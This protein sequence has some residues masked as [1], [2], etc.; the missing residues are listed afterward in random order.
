[1]WGRSV[2]TGRVNRHSVC[3]N[4]GKEEWDWSKKCAVPLP[5]LAYSTHELRKR[6]GTSKSSIQ[7]QGGWEQSLMFMGTRV[8]KGTLF[9]SLWRLLPYRPAD[10]QSIIPFTWQALSWKVNLGVFCL[11]GF[12]VCVV[13][14]VKQKQAVVRGKCSVNVSYCGPTVA[15]N[16]SWETYILS[17]SVECEWSSAMYKS[18]GFTVAAW[19]Q[20]WFEVGMFF[21]FQ[22]PFWWEC[23]YQFLVQL[24]CCFKNECSSY[25]FKREFK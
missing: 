10:S 14:R 7:I 6:N 5:C 13:S 15:L 25:V 12:S 16:E 20:C 9:L 17:L 8:R 21:L 2:L 22:L 19:V 4:V 3:L 24:L 11:F 18:K 1:M 23:K